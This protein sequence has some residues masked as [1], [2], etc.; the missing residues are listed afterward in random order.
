MNNDNINFL[1]LIMDKIDNTKID[2]DHLIWYI[3]YCNSVDETDE[4]IK[5]EN[6]HILPRNLFPEFVNLNKNQWNSSKMNYINHFYAH[7]IL[8]KSI[9]TRGNRFA[10][11][12]MKRTF[13]KI[14][15]KNVGVMA[16]LYTEFREQ[17]SKDF[18]DIN[19]GRPQTDVQRKK[20]SEKQ[21]GCVIVRPKGALLNSPHFKVSIFDPE[22]LNGN[23][24]VNSTGTSKSKETRKLMSENGIKAKK[25]ITTL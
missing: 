8:A 9:K 12:M 13:S 17:L 10:F 5:T 19:K 21:K 11:N 4:N 14:E 25:N 18:S 20:N 16:Q 7:Y 3:L 6:H 23:L 15:S 2:Q 1:S 24:I 22:Y